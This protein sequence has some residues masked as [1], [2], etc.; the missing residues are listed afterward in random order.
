M[1]GETDRQR[2]RDR[3][4]ERQR[5]TKT[6][7]ERQKESG[8]ERE[9]RAGDRQTDRQTDRERDREKER[10]RQRYRYKD[11]QRHTNRETDRQRHTDRQRVRNSKFVFKAGWSVAFKPGALTTRPTRFTE[12]KTLNIPIIIHTLSGCQGML[13]KPQYLLPENRMRAAKRKD[14]SP[15]DL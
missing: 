8:I 12:Q 10:R 13:P 2:Q 11:R 15:R 14:E 7:T 5:E 3:D 4:R 6:E 9:K 1:E